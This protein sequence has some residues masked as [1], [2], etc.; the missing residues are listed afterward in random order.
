LKPQAEETLVLEAHAERLADFIECVLN[1]PD[2]P[3]ETEAT[4]EGLVVFLQSQHAD[5]C[6]F[7]WFRKHE[8]ASHD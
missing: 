8:S 3:K 7:L 5:I 4:L 2:Q 1:L 6:Q